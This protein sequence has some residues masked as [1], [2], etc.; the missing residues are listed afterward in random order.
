MLVRQVMSRHPRPGGPG[1]DVRQA[2]QRMARQRSPAALWWRGQGGGD[3]L[4]MA[5]CGRYEMEISRALTDI[6]ENIRR[7]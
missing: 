7:P 4:L 2:A 3:G 5:K 6:S 1:D